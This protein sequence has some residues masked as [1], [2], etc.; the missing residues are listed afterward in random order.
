MSS[1]NCCFLTCIQISQES[2]QVVWY[3]HLLKN[4]PQCVVIY[5]V[6]GF[7]LINKAEIDVFWNSLAFP[8]IQRM[9]AIWSL[10]PLPCL[11]P[12][13]TSGS[14]WFMYCWSPAWRI[15]S[16]TLLVYE[17]SAIVRL[18]EH[19]LTLPFFEVG[20]KTDLFQ[21]CGHC[22]VFQ[23]CWHTE[24]STLTAS[25]SHAWTPQ[26]QLTAEQPLT[27]EC[28][29]PPKKDTPHPRAKEKP[30]QDGKRGKVAFRIKPNTCQRRSEGSNKTLSHQDPG[31]PQR[32]SQALVFCRGTGQQWL[33]AGAGALGAA[34]LGH[35]ACGISPLRG[36]RH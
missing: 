2:G 11:N 19:P 24:C 12:T 26:L 6:K 10:V 3:P 22:R 36:G 7:G 31:T 29:I 16:I 34:D 25:S 18:F 4:F 9:L 8:M 20:M 1:S 23:I 35:P 27:G 17:M 13:W 33:V 32:L 5:K 28:W 14:S 21:S 30:Q 15:L